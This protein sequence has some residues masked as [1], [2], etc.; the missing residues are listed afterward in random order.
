MKW[1]LAGALLALLW[2]LCPALIVGVATNPIVVAFALGVALRP[3][4]ARKMRGWAA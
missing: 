1:L 2:V 4:M 3:A